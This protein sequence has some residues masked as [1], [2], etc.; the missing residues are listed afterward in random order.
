MK[1]T[2]G[3]DDLDFD[4]GNLSASNPHALNDEKWNANQEEYLDEL[5]TAGIQQLIGQIF[6]LPT[7]RS[8]HGP[9][10]RPRFHTKPTYFVLG[11]L[12]R[13]TCQSQQP[14]FQE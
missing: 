5:A 2:D 6:S 1:D 14:R 11:L 7:E 12:F 4:I 3:A 9:L 8:E 10:V 13:L